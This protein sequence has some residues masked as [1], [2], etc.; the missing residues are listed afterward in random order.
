MPEARLRRTRQT[1]PDDYQYGDAT[2]AAIVAHFAAGGRA[3]GD[4]L[5]RYTADIVKNAPLWESDPSRFARRN[6]QRQTDAMR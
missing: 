4:L 2:K 5:D 1:L 6:T 3:V